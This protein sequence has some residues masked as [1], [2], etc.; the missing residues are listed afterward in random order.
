[1]ARKIGVRPVTDSDS[2]VQATG[3]R[4]TLQSGDAQWV[5]SR[6]RELYD[7]PDPAAEWTRH[8]V[9]DAISDEIQ[10]LSSHNAIVFLD[11]SKVNGSTRTTWA[12]NPAAHEIIEEHRENAEVSDTLLPCDC[13]S[14]AI[15]NPE[16][17]DGIQCKICEEVFDREEIDG[18]LQ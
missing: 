13:P 16:G 17:V 10:G 7:I 5:R 3:R 2:R 11:K 4:K 14:D 15:R 1:M 12:T 8:D 18:G 6:A 9:P